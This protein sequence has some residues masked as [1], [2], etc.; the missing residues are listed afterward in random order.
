MPSG[1][2]VKMTTQAAERCFFA[3]NGL[4]RKNQPGTWNQPPAHTNT[5]PR[6][7]ARQRP[8][9]ARKAYASGDWDMYI[10]LTAS[11]VEGA[12]SF[13]LRA[14]CEDEHARRES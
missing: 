14:T 10:W 8:L 5:N 4:A 1:R 2:R 11:Y 3:K 9:A 6:R 13:A 12:S 7:E